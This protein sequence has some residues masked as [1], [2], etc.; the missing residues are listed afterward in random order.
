[1][2][3]YDNDVG[4]I[5]WADDLGDVGALSLGA[6]RGRGIMRPRRLRAGRLIPRVP[7][8]PAI[9]LRLQP[10]G[11]PSVNFILNSG[12]LLTTIAQ[13]QRPFKGKRLVVDIARTGVTSTGLIAITQLLI[14]TNNQLVSSGPIGAGSFAPS[15]F[16]TNLELSAAT[17][18]INIAIQFSNSIVVTTTDVVSVQPTLFGESIG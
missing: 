14:G 13:P 5:E 9:G 8:A 12:Q 17:T 18:A 16:D 1:M 6:V 11:F 7:G 2:G 15:A 3:D 10:L 4:D